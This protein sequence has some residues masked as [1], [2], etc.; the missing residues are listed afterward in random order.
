M[1]VPVPGREDRGQEVTV[2]EPSIFEA[3]EVG[4]GDGGADREEDWCVIRSGFGEGG[5]RGVRKKQAH[6]VVVEHAVRTR[7]GGGSPVVGPGEEAVK[8]RDVNQAKIANCIVKGLS[9]GH[10]TNVSSFLIE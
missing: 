6:G 9:Y 2:L 8:E 5:E 1:Q 3:E 7:Q 4:L 10:S